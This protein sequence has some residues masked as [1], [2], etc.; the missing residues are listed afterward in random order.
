[1]DH[2]ATVLWD[3]SSS[4]KMLC[5]YVDGNVVDMSMSHKFELSGGPRPINICLCVQVL[6]IGQKSTHEENVLQK[7]Y[8]IFLLLFLLLLKLIRNCLTQIL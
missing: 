5:V 2:G 7:T 4:F 1:M 8:Y 3:L 6:Y